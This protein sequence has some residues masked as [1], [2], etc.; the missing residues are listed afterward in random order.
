ML[1]KQ[2]QAKRDRFLKRML[3]LWHKALME[4]IQPVLDEI[5]E[6]TVNQIAG[7]IP[8]L[9]TPESIATAMTTT[10]DTVA[11]FFAGQTMRDLK[12]AAPDTRQ[13]K[14]DIPTDEEWIQRI[15]SILGAQAGVRITSI[16]DSSRAEAIKI[17]QEV[18]KEGAEQ[19]LGISQLSQLLRDELAKRWGVVSTYRA[20]RIAR[21]EIVNASN[22]GSLA[23]AAESG[24]PLLK[25][26][27]STRDSRTR[28]DTPGGRYPPGR[29]DHYGKF[30]TGP[31]EEKQELR[32][33]F[34][35]TGES[36]QYPGDPVGS[37]GN[38]I[39][40]RCA[41]FFEPKEVNIESVGILT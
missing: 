38:I 36:L 16:T 10:I 24:V 11:P 6:S 32:D 2:T 12:K 9:V 17:I 13:F 33:P 28:R 19:G 18:L 21:T 25:V 37:A 23:G 31:D 14:Q 35:K 41:Q 3:N 34:V 27:L 20:A 1:W 22:L 40:C 15:N 30:P 8:Q 5:D 7:R 26:W 39:N 29:F 4:Q